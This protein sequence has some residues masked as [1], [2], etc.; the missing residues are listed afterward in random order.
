MIKGNTNV[1]YAYDAERLN[2]TQVKCSS[3]GGI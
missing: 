3:L 2:V 1:S